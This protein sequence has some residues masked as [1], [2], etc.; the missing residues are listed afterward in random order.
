VPGFSEIRLT[1]RDKAILSAVSR[2]RFLTSSHILSLVSGSRQNIVRRLQRL[3][4]A[5]FLER[6]K[7]QLPLRYSRELSEFVYSPTRKTLSHLS[8]QVGE[9]NSRGKSTPA[10]SLFLAHSLSISEALIR[11]ETD[12]R[13]RGIAFTA[14][15]DILGAQTATGT[16]HLAWRVT[17]RAGDDTENVGVIPDSTFAIERPDHSGNQRRLYFF[18]ET[19]RG[20]MPLHR[21]SL[22]QSSIY[23]KVLAYSRTRRSCILKDKYGI[24]GFQVI[25][26]ARSKARLEHIKTLCEETGAKRGSSLFLFVTIEELRNDR[27]QIITIL[28]GD[29]VSG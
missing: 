1:D 10:S 27:N 21:R 3:Y 25:F 16:K 28:S 15:G 5:G 11:I 22:R 18:L 4:H 20:T 12:C 23:R 26:V 7:A 13:L 29:S 14:E 9:T 6:P 19:D 17:I 2:H 8:A 24:L